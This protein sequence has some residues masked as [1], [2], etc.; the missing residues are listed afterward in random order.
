MLHNNILDILDNIDKIKMLWYNNVIADKA[1]VN[2]T[3][4]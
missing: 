4:L 3:F 2:S 1:I